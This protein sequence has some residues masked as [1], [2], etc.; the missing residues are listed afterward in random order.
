MAVEPTNTEP[1]VDPSASDAQV[2]ATPILQRL[3]SVDAYRGFVMLLMM[4]EIMHLNRIAKAFPDNPVWQ[5][6]SAQQSHVEW[7]GCTLHDLI[8]PSF[9]FLVGV[10]VVLSLDMRR[11][12]GDNPAKFI[13]HAAWRALVLTF[14][15][16]WLR[17]LGKS[18]INFTFEDTLTQIG[19]GFFPL[20]LIALCAKRVWWICL[21]IILVGYWG[22][23]ALYPAPAPDF[24]YPKVGVPDTWNENSTGFSAHWNKNSNLAWKFDT[25]FLNLFPRPKPFEYNGGGYST[26]NFIPTLATSLLGLIAGGWLL[27]AATASRKLALFAT[28][29]A[30]CLI[31]GFALDYLG[32]CPSVK[33]IW[34]PAWVLF[35]GG[36]CFL[37]LALFFLMADATS[38]TLWS[39]PLRVLGMNPIASYLISHLLEG[40]IRLNFAL[41]LGKEF[42]RFGGQAYEPLFIGL[43]ILTVDW[44]ILAWMERRK[45]FLR[46]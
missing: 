42:F 24:D 18:Q 43:G 16:V 46:I 17:S 6:L 38:F 12:R 15:G 3:T 31:A 21:A 37:L 19:L 44:I 40:F 45:I 10:S 22:A 7:R 26:L 2:P 14:L 32:I 9:S 34:T 29:G 25:W 33:R 39:Y 4:A 11:R 36:C 8:Q 23:F 41:L 13:T 20:F 28:A 1:A 35:S 27:S 30:I 5:F